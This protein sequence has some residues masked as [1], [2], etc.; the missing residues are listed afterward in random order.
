MAIW[1]FTKRNTDNNIIFLL[2]QAE[3][4][5]AEDRGII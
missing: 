3:S 1:K 4:Y 2:S 5:F